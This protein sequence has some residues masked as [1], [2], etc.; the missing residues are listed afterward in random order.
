[1]EEMRNAFEILVGRPERKIPVGRPRF[2][3][4]NNFRMDLR[5]TV[6]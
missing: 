2:G 3:R 4:E 6:D 1:V 5:E